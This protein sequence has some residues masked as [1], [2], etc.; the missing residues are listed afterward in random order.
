MTAVHGSVGSLKSTHRALSSLRLAPVATGVSEMGEKSVKTL[1][2]A[3][4]YKLANLRNHAEIEHLD[5]CI[6]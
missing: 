6:D 5:L 4:E 2:L 1:R 3:H